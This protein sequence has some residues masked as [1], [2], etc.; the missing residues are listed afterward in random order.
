M[1]IF[2]SLVINIIMLASWDAKGA[3]SEDMDVLG[4]LPESIDEYVINIII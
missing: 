4:Q 2:L 3:L 1:C